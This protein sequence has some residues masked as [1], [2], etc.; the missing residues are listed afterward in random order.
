MQNSVLY[1]LR[2]AALV[3]LGAITILAAS[4]YASLYVRSLLLE[5]G[6]AAAVGVIGGLFAVLLLIFVAA[7]AVAWTFMLHHGHR[8]TH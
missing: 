7:F 8:H 1:S 6:V 3:S 4:F 2:I 5:S